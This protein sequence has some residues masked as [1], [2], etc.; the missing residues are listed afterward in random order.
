V[1]ELWCGDLNINLISPN[2]Y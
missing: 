2:A 1:T